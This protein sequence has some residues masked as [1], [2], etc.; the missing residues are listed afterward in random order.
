MKTN[1]AI[2]ITNALLLTPALVMGIEPQLESVERVRVDFGAYDQYDD[3]GLSITTEN[4]IPD[5]NG[6]WSMIAA[7][8]AGALSQDEGPD[9]VRTGAQIGLKQYFSELASL[10]LSGGA[11]WYYDGPSYDMMMAELE[12]IQLF[13]SP[14][15]PIVPY[16]RS[17]G[18]IDFIDP[19]RQGPSKQSQ[20]YEQAVLELALGL[21]VKAR[22][23]FRWVFE[24][25]YSES[26]AIDD[27]GPEIA[28]GWLVQVAMQ[29]DWF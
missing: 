15:E 8:S 2:F 25:G 27:G 20:D 4:P 11:T 18:R 17:A 1:A 23:H 9:Y 22:D 7:I 10:S 3:I 24:G 16:V 29:Y 21:H 14:D 19:S 12:Y 6:K 26:A 28:D 13:A 5:T